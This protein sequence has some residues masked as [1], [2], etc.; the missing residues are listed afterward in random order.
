MKA[1][2]TAAPYRSPLL[3]AACMCGRPGV[4]C[5]TCS[6]WRRHYTVVSARRAAWQK[7]VR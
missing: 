4:V 6:R 5:M 1:T 3:F 7:E 2:E